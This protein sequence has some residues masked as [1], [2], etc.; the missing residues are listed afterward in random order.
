MSD[1]ETAT[2]YQLKVKVINFVE[3]AYK[4]NGDITASLI[5]SRGS[6]TLKV[7][8]KGEAVLSGKAGMV[9]FSVKNE[10]K[11]FGID[12]KVASIMFSGNRNGKIHYTAFFNF[13]GGAKVEF[14]SIVDVEKLIL[15]CSGLLCQAA[16][17][18]KNRHKQ[19]DQ[20]LYQ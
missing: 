10:I 6:F 1:N 11:Q 19:I 5:K 12:L 13:M 18:L 8:D 7:N 15:S 4:S 20:S 3:L 2:S 9:R 17:L 14:S 16:R